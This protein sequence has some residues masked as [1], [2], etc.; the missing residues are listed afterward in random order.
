MLLSELVQILQ[1]L[2]DSEG[3]MEAIVASGFECEAVN[4]AG[5]V[6]H[7]DKICLLID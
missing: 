3:D 5:F 1:E 2:L 7:D 6:H 4:F